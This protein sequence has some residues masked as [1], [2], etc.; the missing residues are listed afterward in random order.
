MGN[1][2][3]SQYVLQHKLNIYFKNHGNLIGTKSYQRFTNLGHFKSMLE[4]GRV[5]DWIT[6][7]NSEFHSISLVFAEPQ[8]GMMFW[9]NWFLHNKGMAYIF[10]PLLFCSLNRFLCFLHF[11]KILYYGCSCLFSCFSPPALGGGLPRPN[12]VSHL[13]EKLLSWGEK[14]S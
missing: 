10:P 9:K 8:T 3:K 2:W 14:P 11:S 4:L 13:G 6:S 1:E 7:N 12:P 5:P